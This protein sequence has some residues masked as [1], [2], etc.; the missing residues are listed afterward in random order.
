M[1]W[2]ISDLVNKSPIIFEMWINSPKSMNQFVKDTSI[3][4]QSLYCFHS[5]IVPP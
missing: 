4:M 3:I 5:K 1:K 2:Y